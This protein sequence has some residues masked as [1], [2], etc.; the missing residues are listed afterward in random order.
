MYKNKEDFVMII[1][2]KERTG[3][4]TLA[5]HIGAYVDPT[6]I[7]D[8]SRICLSPEEFKEKV[9]KS[10]KQCII[11]DEAHRG[12][13]S[14]RAIT[15]VNQLLTSLTMEM[16]VRNL[17]V[18]IVLPTFFE[19]EKYPAISRARILLHTYR[20]NGKKGFWRFVGWKDKQQLYL[21]GK[22]DYNYNYIRS[23]FK[24]RFLPG[25]MV[26]EKLYDKK[27]DKSF[28]EGFGEKKEGENKYLTQRNQVISLLATFNEL[29]VTEVARLFK[30]SGIEL[31]YTQIRE[32]INQFK[33]P[34]KEPVTKT[35]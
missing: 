33:E 10:K 26:D 14:R 25:Y 28:K 30:N 2:G 4:S 32:A 27:K 18:I 9:T 3:K 12:M 22:R 17:F 29:P 24:G 23:K 19:L 20:R 6:L 15:Q 16:G 31:K 5:Q 1:D 8:L 13:S 21:K 35:S 34:R 7:G 11:F